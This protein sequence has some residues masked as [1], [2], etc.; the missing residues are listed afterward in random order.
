MIEQEMR[1]YLADGA[2]SADNYYLRIAPGNSAMPLGIVF[3]VAPGKRYTHSDP[4]GSLNDS[5]MQCSCYGRSYYEAKTL[6]QEVIE[7]MHGWEAA[8]AEVQAVFLMNE[9]DLYD[10][11]TKIH[12]V[13]LQFIVWHTF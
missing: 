1:Q 8:E 4:D 13:A 3:K 11:A 12:H 6:A 5:I 10:D 2:T 9:N 7:L